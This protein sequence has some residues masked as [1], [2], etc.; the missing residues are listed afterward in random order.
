MGGALFMIYYNQNSLIYPARFPPGSR[1]EVATPN[2]F[3]MPDWEDVTLTT[4]DKVTIKGYLIRRRPRTNVSTDDASSQLRQRKEDAKAPLAEYTL[5]YCHANAGNMGHRLP[6]ANRFYHKCNTNVFMLSYRGYGKSDGSP[7]EKG[8]KIDAQAALDYITS[9]PELKN[10]KIVIYGQSIGGAVAVDLAARNEEQVHALIVE[11]TFTTLRKLIPHVMPYLNWVSFLC[12]QIWDTEAAIKQL[13]R[14]PILMLSGGMDELIPPS[15]MI[16][17]C[18]GA[19]AARRS[20]SE[21]EEVEGGEAVE[22]DGNG[23]RFVILPDGTHN[24]TCMKAGYFEEIVRFWRE[25]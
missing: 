7:S 5:L 23:I 25:L 20:G 9:H 10:T 19:R 15:Q 17:L 11:N 22:E 24:D 1:E 12:H 13:R 8:L 14:I 21:K 16:E 6:I 2:E 3:G 4:P 18:R